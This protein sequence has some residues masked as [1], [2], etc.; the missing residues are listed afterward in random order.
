MDELVSWFRY[1]LGGHGGK[2]A[3]ALPQLMYVRVQFYR[4]NAM[5]AVRGCHYNEEDRRE[6]ARGLG[7]GGR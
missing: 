4:S 7:E 3:G 2:M 6:G 5:Y 1:R